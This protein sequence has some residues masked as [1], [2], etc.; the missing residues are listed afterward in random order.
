M[1]STRVN[2]L[3]KALEGFDHLGTWVQESEGG[4]VRRDRIESILDGRAISITDERQGK[5]GEW[6]QHGH[7]VITW[8]PIRQSVIYRGSSL[9]GF[10][11]EAVVES[12]T[13]DGQK[14]I[15]VTR[16]QGAGPDGAAVIARLTRMI[17]GDKMTLKFN[18]VRTSNLEEEPLWIGSAVELSRA[19]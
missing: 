16:G 1:E 9:T 13:F 10:T 4:Q 14:G 15:M 19:K 11:Y 8:D 3:A 7:A 2:P 12:L 6:V 18:S 17:D 5:D